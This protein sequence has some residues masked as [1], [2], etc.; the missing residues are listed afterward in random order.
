MTWSRIPPKVL[1]AYSPEDWKEA[2]DFIRFFANDL[3]VF[4]PILVEQDEDLL[5]AGC[6][7]YDLFP[8]R[9]SF[10]QDS[11]ITMVLLGKNTY[12]YKYVDRII[13][14]S[15][16]HGDFLPNGLL[17]VNLPSVKNDALLPIRL[18][19]NYDRN[20]QKSYAR[21][22]LHPQSVVPFGEYLDDAVQ[23]R[24]ERAYLINN[25]DIL[26]QRGRGY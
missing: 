20:P 25:P 19:L 11:T 17:G 2:Q 8:V 9:A 12:R 6:P 15:L 10:L 4:T 7:A 14:A 3:G 16:E 26:L 1:V 18:R 21:H 23:A 13:E 5:Y 24:T 22:L